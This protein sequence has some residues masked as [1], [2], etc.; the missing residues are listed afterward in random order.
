M[1]RRLGSL[2]NDGQ[3]EKIQG[4]R[5]SADRSGGQKQIASRGRETAMAQQELDFAYVGS[6]LQ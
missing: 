4:A 2:I 6:G 5:G 1:Q 3:R